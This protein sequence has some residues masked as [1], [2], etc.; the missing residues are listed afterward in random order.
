M[1]FTLKS[2]KE[3]VHIFRTTMIGPLSPCFFF[4][5]FFFVGGG[6][7]LDQYKHLS[8]NHWT[9]SGIAFDQMSGIIYWI[10]L[11]KEQ[12]EPFRNK[13]KVNKQ[14]KY[15][16]SHNELWM[17]YAHCMS[18]LSP[19]ILVFFDLLEVDNFNQFEYLQKLTFF[20]QCDAFYS[21][22]GLHPS[23]LGSTCL[24]KTWKNK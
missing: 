10:L 1:Y 7:V 15:L 18:F 21:S 20:W 11:W 8:D 13:R 24:P 6:S 23:R 17:F 3:N 12:T 9:G 5:L 14:T 16:K 22:N 4:G 2:L 19:L